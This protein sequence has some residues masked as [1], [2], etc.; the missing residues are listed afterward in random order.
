M[1]AGPPD[2]DP[3]VRSALNEAGD[4]LSSGDVAGALDVY[5]RTWHE[6]AAKG[7][8]FHACVVAHMAG[9]AETDGVKK[10]RWNV[11]ALAEA[12]AAP[13]LIRARGMYAS[14]YNNLGMSC[15]IQGDR[16]EALRYF[17]LAASHLDEIAPGPYADQVRAG[18]ERNLARLRP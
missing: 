2:F 16:Q 14:L 3:K 8:H 10:H 15:S 13:E 6:L 9:V 1:R 18:I 5:R 11:A 7:D 17:E 12:N 4:L